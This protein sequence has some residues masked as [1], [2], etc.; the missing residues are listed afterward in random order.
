[1]NETKSITIADCIDTAGK[2]P[3]AVG[4]RDEFDN[5]LRFLWEERDNEWLQN[6]LVGHLASGFMDMLHVAQRAGISA[7][8]IEAAI[9][10]E[11][12]R[13][14]KA[15]ARYTPPEPSTTEAL[16]VSDE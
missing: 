15:I 3:L 14:E 16:G 12:E 9:R 1:M 5:T 4:G 7:E 11:Y 10:L 6:S 2:S 13:H 8:Q